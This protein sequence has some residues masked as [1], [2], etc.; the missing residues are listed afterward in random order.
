VFGRNIT[1]TA[2]DAR[3]NT[4]EFSP[5]FAAGSSLSPVT[6]TVV[7]TS[8]GGPGSLRDAIMNNDNQASSGANTILF[9]IPGPGP[10][11]ITP[12]IALPPITETVFID[13]YSQPGSAMNTLSN[14]WNGV[15][16][17]IIDS[18]L[19]TDGLVFT[20]GGNTVRGLCVTRFTQHGLMFSGG[21]NNVLQGNLIG[22]S[23][24]GVNRGNY[25]G[26]TFDQ[27]S[28]N[29]VGG[30]APSQ[31][32]VIA[33]NN[34]GGGLMFLG[35]AGSHDQ[36]VQGNFIG[37][38]LQGTNATS[39]A[40]DG[41]GFN[42]VLRGLIGG[43]TPGARNIIAG[44]AGLVNSGLVTVQG[45]YFGV[46]V[47]G[48][49]RFL[50][51]VSG[52]SISGGSSNIVGGITAA[53]RNVLSTTI[54]I[55]GGANT[56]KGNYIGVDVTGTNL[57]GGADAGISISSGYS[58]NII[59]GT[60]PGAGNLIA[61]FTYGILINT[62]GT[63]Y[64]RGNFIGTDPTGMRRFGNIANGIHIVVAT[65]NII[66]GINPGEANLIAYNRGNGV[67]ILSGSNNVIRGNSIYAN[68]NLAIDLGPAGVTANDVGDGD[69]GQNQLQ[70]FP[71]L[72]GATNFGNSLTIAGTLSSATNA[73]FIVDFYAQTGCD[74]SGYGEG[75]QY[76]GSTSVMTG[77]D[78][79][80]NFLVSLGG[81]TPIGDVITATAT[82]ASGNT[83]EF[84]ACQTAVPFI[85]PT[86][87]FTVLGSSPTQEAKVSWPS[88]VSGFHLQT[89]S[90]LNLPI[91]WSNVT[92]S[93]NDDNT[94]KSISLSINTNEPMRFFRLV[95]P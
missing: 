12:A 37:T 72:T 94:N 69:S 56:V 81:V 87:A 86:I 28:G 74:N 16:Q 3:G 30:T 10:F 23:P 64:I 61:G 82:D 18:P 84:S 22:I 14:G 54:S 2:T 53:A 8:D 11:T 42:S 31:R 59:G 27:S 7:N 51:L 90:N 38:G 40:P 48:T 93:V 17:I 66:G 15:V 1:A 47:T 57:L 45:N 71:V 44:G 85:Q 41:V 58:E 52:V 34:N 35:A 50:G 25:T 26:V 55:F 91:F 4:S 60:E 39:L 43:T 75:Q 6:F 78:G 33:F 62:S 65:G 80:K 88:S 77:A 21:D 46:S 32:N 29:L 70:N 20:T 76:L 95:S 49:N 79:T 24:A 9:D 89:A 92:N 13:G 67:Y 5:C 36:T 63:N 83:S 68:T 73:T 19:I